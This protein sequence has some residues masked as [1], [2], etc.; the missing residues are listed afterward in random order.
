MTRADEKGVA[1]TLVFPLP[2][3]G[4]WSRLF[5]SPRD[6]YPFWSLTCELSC[7]H[8]LPELADNQIRHLSSSRA[9]PSRSVFPPSRS[10]SCPS[11]RSCRSSICSSCHFKPRTSFS[12]RW[13]TLLHTTSPRE[14]STRPLQRCSSSSASKGYA[15]GQLMSIHSTMWV[16]SGAIMRGM[17]R[18]HRRRIERQRSKR[19]SWRESLG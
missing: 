4:I 17:Y 5:K 7:L 11:R 8:L 12:P 10:A 2:T 18:V 6:Y 14:G 15:A 1:P 3:E 19:E 9:P 13:N 16:G